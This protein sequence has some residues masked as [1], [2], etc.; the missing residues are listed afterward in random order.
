LDELVLLSPSKLKAK[1]EELEEGGVFSE[2]GIR[3]FLEGD[4]FA[5]YIDIW[6]SETR[7]VVTS[8]AKKLSEYEPATAT[9]EPDEVRDLLKKLYQYL[10]PRKIRHDLGEF[11]T[12]D[13][14]AELTLNEVGYD[15]STDVRLLDPACGSGSFLVLAIKRIKE[16]ADAEKLS[17]N[18]ILEKILENI[19]GFDLNP[20][21]VIAA[22]TNYLIALGDLVRRRKHDIFIPVY[23][24]DSIAMARPKQEALE[25]PVFEVATSVGKFIVPAA[26][27][28]EKLIDPI[29]S[30]ADESIRNRYK[31]SEFLERINHDFHELD[32]RSLPLL[33]E[34]YEK[35]L[36]LELKGI[37]RI[38]A[39]LLKNA[40]AP[41]FCDKFDLVV[42]NPPWINWEY[43]PEDYRN[44]TKS[45]WT[46]YGLI[47]DSGK[48]GLGQLRRDLATLF[49]ARCAEQ[50]LQPAGKLGFLMP[51]NV[52]KTQGGDGFRRFLSRKTEV[53][54]VH[55]LS[56]TYPFEGA[57]NRT[58]L[59]VLGHGR[60][61]FPIA[62]TIWYNEKSA[63]LDQELS[64]DAVRGMT[65]RFELNLAP[66]QKA[67]PNSPWAMTTA[68]AY[69]ALSKI[70]RPSP[71]RG[72]EGIKTALN[73]IYW[74]EIKAIYME[75]F[76][77]IQNVGWGKIEVPQN[78]GNVE[79]DL[80]YPVVRGNDVLRWYTDPKYYIIAP[81]DTRTGRP[82]E[83]QR[84]KVEFPKTYQFLL[85]FKQNLANRSIHKLWGKD[86]P[87]YSLYD[88]GS[89]TFQPYK[90]VWKDISGKISARGDFGG[91]AVIGK[92][93]DVNLGKVQL[94]PDATLMFIPCKSEDEAHYLC[95]SLNS[96]FTRFVATCYAVL[97]VG[98]HVLKYTDIRQYDANNPNHQKLAELSK[99]AHLLAVEIHER[100][101]FSARD[102]LQ[103]IEGGI[104]QVL[105]KAYGI[106][107]DELDEIRNTM[108]IL[109]EGEGLEEDVN[110]SNSIED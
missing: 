64:L 33:K 14:L 47:S 27:V 105:A 65:K 73:G 86:N 31:A 74:T 101:D 18:S 59:L 48:I 71:Y 104:D 60:T 62:C 57:T 97:H 29:F 108:K 11:F 66:I 87:F 46:Q 39:R 99:K 98:Q 26:I 15:G 35:L 55:D 100:S 7:E 50:Y 4:F 8:V 34:L 20:L 1:L 95:A 13:W 53:S 16:K 52:F 24:S 37:N 21:A 102:R 63:G 78:Q 94:L 81:H 41:L 30:I 75:K 110:S 10:V 56:E 45:L 3:N 103:V 43:L 2:S 19:V 109:K 85:K 38:W 83:E 5:W 84:L 88:I 77:T 76:A 9:L 91:A 12:P 42:G 89:Y 32:E 90:V 23:L 70:S 6:N 68:K 51:F 25:G 49:V 22:R 28:Q 79:K 69:E 44:S 106:L 54:S 92:K 36:A 61:R 17:Q 40:F 96:I 72:Y 82:L 80:V 93:K 58:G 107:D 67:E